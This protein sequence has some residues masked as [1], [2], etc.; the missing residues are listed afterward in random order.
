MLPIF[1]SFPGV[2]EDF[3]SSH[4]LGI[5]ALES[6]EFE[7]ALDYFKLELIEAK[8]I[9]NKTSE[10]TGYNDLGLAYNLSLIHI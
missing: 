5:E 3:L 4:H 7:T 6:G 1:Q 9:G 8:E 10:G 2:E